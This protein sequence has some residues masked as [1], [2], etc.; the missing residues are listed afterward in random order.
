MTCGKDPDEV[1]NLAAD[2]RHGTVIGELRA[3]LDAHLLA[4]NDNGFIPE[5]S[6]LEGYDASRAPGAYPL[7]EVMLVAGT[8]IERRAA[9][10]GRLARWLA[11]DNECVRYWAA[12]GCVML[13]HEA[14]GAKDDLAARVDDASWSVRIAAAHALCWLHEED[15]GLAVLSEALLEHEHQRVRLQAANALDELG[16]LA[17]PALPALEQAHNDPDQEVRWAADYTAAILAG[18]RSYADGLTLGVPGSG[19]TAGRPARVTARL[20]NTAQ[21]A[22]VHVR[23]AVAAPEGWHV[24][25]ASPSSFAA[26]APGETVEA[27]FDIT[28]PAGVAGEHHIGGIATYDSGGR[29]VTTRVREPVRVT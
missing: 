16:H 23:L 20:Y 17:L 4:A 8:A 25:P 28:A 26:V 2:A 5:G 14:E 7:A 9:N 13:R 29:A 21:D 15:Q 18:E 10:T 27:A 6:P 24:Q 3:A 19:L 22:R 1:T 12:L 11:H